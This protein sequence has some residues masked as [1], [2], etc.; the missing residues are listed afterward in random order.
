M[1]INIL[2]GQLTDLA[3]A[4][5]SM[6]IGNMKQTT[7]PS[8]FIHR[9]GRYFPILSCSAAQQRTVIRPPDKRPHAP[10]LIHATQKNTLRKT[11]LPMHR[12]FFFAYARPSVAA[13]AIGHHIQQWHAIV[14]SSV[15]PLQVTSYS[16]DQGNSYLLALFRQNQA[17][18]AIYS[19]P[20]GRFA[21]C[22]PRAGSRH[23]VPVDRA[24]NPSWQWHYHSTAS[25][26]RLKWFLRVF[27][28]S[29]SNIRSATS[30]PRCCQ[31]PVF[32]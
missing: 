23:F 2:S 29:Y 18:D 8:F 10:N 28:P 22:V 30:S 12:C 31:S 20:P 27:F 17:R 15:L 5:C 4:L 13:C 25:C 16:Y 7:P 1:Q 9:K 14:A 21:T 3:M 24:R 6:H 32:F 11:L 26:T 19:I